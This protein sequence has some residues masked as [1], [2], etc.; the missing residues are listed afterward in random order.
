MNQTRDDV[1]LALHRKIAALELHN[2]RLERQVEELRA[3]VAALLAP[4]P[5]RPVSSREPLPPYGR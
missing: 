3:A 5:V 2:K 1:L 4:P